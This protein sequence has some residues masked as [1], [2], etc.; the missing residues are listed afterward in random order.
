MVSVAGTRPP[1]KET[2]V[3]DMKYLD[4]EAVVTD[5]SFLGMAFA[6]AV[7]ESS[8]FHQLR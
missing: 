2:A 6:L 7:A 3:V 5:S 4:K 1:D 8:A